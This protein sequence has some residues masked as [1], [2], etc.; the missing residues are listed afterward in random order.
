MA[1]GTDEAAPDRRGLSATQAAE[2]LAAD[3]PNELPRNKGRSFLRIA[4]D[5]LLEPMFALLLAAGIIY[6]ALGDRG[7]AFILMVFATL[8]IGIAIAQESRSER[9][10]ESLRDLTAPEATVV[11][12]GIRQRIRAREV[13]RG[14]LLAIGEGE[15]V[16]ADA[17]VVWAQDLMADESLLTGESV[18]VRKGVAQGEVAPDDLHPGGDDIP[19]VFSGTL[20]VRGQALACV[21][22]TGAATEI[23]K[24]GTALR[25]IESVPPRLT[26]Q[27]RRLVAIVAV[28]G[29]SVTLAM[30]IL[31]GLLRGDWLH[32][33]LGGIAL[34]MSMLPEEFPL[35]LTVFMVMGAW[36][37]SRERVLTRRAAAIETL[38]AATVLCTDKT[39]TLTENRMRIVELRAGDTVLRASRGAPDGVPDAAASLV[40]CGLLACARDPFDPMEQAFYAFRDAHLA[41]RPHPHDDRAPSHEWG[42]SPQLLAVTKAWSSTS[43]DDD[44]VAAKGA[45]EAIFRLCRLD[46]AHAAS[47]HRE[48]EEMAEHGLRVL[49][50]AC[51]RACAPGSPGEECWPDTPEAGGF[52]FEFV[53]LVGLADPLRAHVS[54]AVAECRSAGIQVVMITGDHPVTARAIAQQA[55]LEHSGVLTGAELEAMSDEE[56]AAAVEGVGVFARIAPIQKLRIVQAFKARGEVVA[57]TGDGVN[58]APSLKAA[59]IAVAM[60]QRGTDVAREAASIVLL[61]DDF[62][63]IVRTIRL[64][65]RIYDNLRKAMGYIVALH[66]P[67]GGMA[68]LPLLTGM[69]IMFAPIH[70]AFLEMVIDPVCSVVFEAESEERNIMRRPPRAPDT[71]LFSRAL[72]G[73]AMVQGFLALVAAAGMYLLGMLRGSEEQ[74]VRALAFVTLVLTNL[75][76]VAVN[77]SFASSP[78]DLI[79]RPNPAF[80]L[81]VAVVVPLLAVTV[82]WRP[83]ETLFDF[84]DLSLGD[85][86]MCAGA[87]LAVFVVLEAL[88]GFWH[89]RL[90][91]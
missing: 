47:L 84:G 42:L 68:L 78:L 70:I 50:V 28:A 48:V 9:M 91:E 26:I 25:E 75:A 11:R 36:R 87:A 57:M 12:D 8:S 4:R 62:L 59:D 16:P 15:R 33:V 82:S 24:I 49:G 83:A 52:A 7:E 46:E 86:A 54:D 22:A 63:S 55:G 60:G 20:A 29:L 17:E 88:K 61:D 74:D 39:G 6:L 67:I 37:I 64:G 76:L 13:V 41:H 53:G 45:P 71:P 66:I 14:D 35:V 90:A 10:L 18:P 89:R 23:G 3:G 73:W 30:V 56:L 19:F 40:E 58:D 85:V 27:T 38:G 21:R 69:P 44:I 79:R 77:R 34:G 5:I 1:N 65:R 51:A 2:R 43:G 72:I 31:F 80:W 32:A 81:S